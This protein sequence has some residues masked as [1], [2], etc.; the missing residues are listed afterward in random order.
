VNIVIH[1]ANSVL[2]VYVSLAMLD[3]TTDDARATFVAVFAG[4]MFAAHPVHAESTSNITGRAELLSALF[5]HI[6]FLVYARS[7]RRP[8]TS[9]AAASASAVDD[10][11][12]PQHFTPSF[13]MPLTHWRGWLATLVALLCAL[14]SLLSKEHGIT[15]PVMIVVFDFL[16]V[17]NLSAGDV[18]NPR[19][20]RASV[21]R[22]MVRTMALAL[23]TIAIAIWR[24]NL[25][26]G[27]PPN[28]W[29][30][31]VFLCLSFGFFVTLVRSLL[32]PLRILLRLHHCEKL[33]L[34]I[35]IA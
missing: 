32:H 9:T 1:A 30:D 14:C 6:G 35:I 26:G 2:L 3:A 23:C 16:I 10:D 8:R 25:N 4:A 29:H 12:D 11:R 22:W 24:H 21:L 7:W 18:L 17:A 20:W 28:L 34:F 15:L 33:V 27:S 19:R 31:Q 5:Y 13:D